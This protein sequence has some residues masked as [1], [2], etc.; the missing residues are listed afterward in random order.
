MKNIIK[1]ILSI[2]VFSLLFSCNKVMDTQPFET[3][4]GDQAFSSVSS[5]QAVL[6]QCYSDVLGYYSGQYASMESYT[7]NGI[8][9]D[10]NSRDNFP[11]ENGINASTWNGD[12]GRFVK[13][14][15][16]NLV[17]ENAENTNVLTDQSKK[18]I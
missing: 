17:I 6:A 15:R 8:H 13:L 16:I 10:L 14:R 2:L 18:E 7:P 9:S 11:L 1:Y 5:F 12:M 3:L 4:D